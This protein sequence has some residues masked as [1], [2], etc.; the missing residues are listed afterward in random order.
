MLLQQPEATRALQDV[1][2]DPV[3]LIDFV[4][5]I[6]GEADIISFGRFMETVLLLRGSNNATVKDIV[7]IRKRLVAEVRLIGDAIVAKMHKSTLAPSRDG[8]NL[9]NFQSQSRR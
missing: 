8:D 1:G 7:D 4:D 2:V 9:A 6:F 3:G 5:V